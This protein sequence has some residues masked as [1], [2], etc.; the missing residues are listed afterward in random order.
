M[1]AK[2]KSASVATGA[3]D[4]IEK[5]IGISPDG[6]D[7]SLELLILLGVIALG[8]AL[9]LLVVRRSRRSR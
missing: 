4:W 9:G 6:G 3:M 2:C 1:T 7:G 8:V 5:L